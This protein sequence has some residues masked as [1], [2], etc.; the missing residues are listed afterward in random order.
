MK[1]RCS[2]PRWWTRWVFAIGAV[3]SLV[4]PVLSLPPET[5]PAPS[6]KRG[7]PQWVAEGHLLDARGQVRWELFT[8]EEASRLRTVMEKGR[9]SREESGRPVDDPGCDMSVIDSGFP[10]SGPP[11]LRTFWEESPIVVLGEVAGSRPGLHLG[12]PVRLFEVSVERVFKPQTA[13]W[14]VSTVF[15]PIP[16]AKVRLDGVDFCSR[17]PRERAPLQ[18]GTRMLVFTQFEASPAVPLLRT[19]P[20]RILFELPDGSVDAPDYLHE[21]GVPVTLDAIVELLEGWR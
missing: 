6:P 15:V 3:T 21:S 20:D 5:L 10:S 17:L 8:P 2:S 4:L 11:S 16:G 13:G 14:N 19:H 9:R 1:T 12:S 18:Q 7:V